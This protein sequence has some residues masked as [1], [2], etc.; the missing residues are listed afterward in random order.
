[1]D[2]PASHVW[3]T[4]VKLV[5]NHAQ[6]GLHEHVWTGWGL[7][8]FEAAW[9]TSSPAIIESQPLEMM[10]I[11]GTSHQPH[12]LAT[13]NSQ[14][15]LEFE[16]NSIAYGL[17]RYRSY[18]QFPR[19]AVPFFISFH[20]SWWSNMCHYI[21]TF[22]FSGTPMKPHPTISHHFLYYLSKLKL[23]FRKTKTWF[24]SNTPQTEMCLFDGQAIVS[25]SKW[26]K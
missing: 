23:Y 20:R 22:H 4:E 26:S 1:M 2:F 19:C 18:I 16:N 21:L 12:G 10:N 9:K 7:E 8:P 6:K 14:F 24:M 13:I 5:L 17:C 15:S 3:W 25:S 11:F